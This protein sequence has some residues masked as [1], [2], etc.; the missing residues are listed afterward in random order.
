VEFKGLKLKNLGEEK[1][2]EPSEDSLY[3]K[4]GGAPVVEKLVKRF[5]HLMDTLEEAKELR[6]MHEGDLQPI[7]EKLILFLTGWLGGPPLYVQKYGHPKLRAR[8]L[9]FSIG[10][11]ERD[12]WILCMF[13]AM[14]DCQIE[15]EVALLTKSALFRLADHM[16][17]QEES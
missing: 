14:D 12:Q 8:H 9:P 11:K 16:R 7:I 13:R 5:Y 6:V 2:Q 4:M 10:E 15:G 1:K 17:N 3:L